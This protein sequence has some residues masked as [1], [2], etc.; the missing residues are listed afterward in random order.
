M[1]TGYIDAE[2]LAESRLRYQVDIVGQVMPDNVVG[3]KRSRT[4]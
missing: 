3:C 4:L 1:D 2:A